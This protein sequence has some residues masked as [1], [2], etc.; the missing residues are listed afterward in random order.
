MDHGAQGVVSP[1]RQSGRCSGIR[2]QCCRCCRPWTSTTPLPPPPPAG[3]APPADHTRQS[4]LPRQGRDAASDSA[5]ASGRQQPDRANAGERELVLHRGDL[6]HG[7]LGEAPDRDVADLDPS[8]RGR[9]CAVVARVR[10]S[11]DEMRHDAVGRGKQV[12]D[13]DREISES[14]VAFGDTL[15][16]PRRTDQDPVRSQVRAEDLIGECKVISPPPREPT[17]CS[18]NGTKT[19]RSLG[20][21][22]R[23]SRRA[24]RSTSVPRALRPQC[25][26]PPRVRS[27]AQAST[28][29]GTARRSTCPGTYPRTEFRC[30]SNGITRYATARSV[31]GSTLATPDVQPDRV[32]AAALGWDH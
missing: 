15:L 11:P 8:P 4:P 19:P 10:T 12:Q 28:A 22:R 5:Y 29:A 14:G 2:K 18:P 3:S 1:D 24:R 27:I 31:T 26:P 21:T 13:L 23:N 30:A 32:P 20:S 25:A 6:D 9:Y 17:R 7:A 16:G